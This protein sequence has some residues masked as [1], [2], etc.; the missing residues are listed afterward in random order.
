[1]TST[2]V[3]DNPDLWYHKNPNLLRANVSRRFTTEQAIEIAKCQEDIIYF[4][5]K[6]IKIVSLDHGVVPFDLWPFQEK[7]INT[8]MKERFTICKMPRQVGKSTT[9]VAFLLHYILFNKNVNVAI[10]ANKG[11][12]ARELLSR[13][14]LAYEQLPSFLKPGVVV[15]NKGN[16]E[17]E[18]GS[19]VLAT[20]TSASSVRGSSFNVIFLDELAHVPMNLAEEFFTS[21]YP[22][23]TSGQNTKI[24]IVSTPNGLNMFYRFWVK[25][26][27]ADG[28]PNKNEYTPIEVHWSEVPGRDDA[29]KAQTIANTS[30]EQFRQEFETE[31]LGS[32]DTLISSSRLQLLNEVDQ[33]KPIY[34]QEDLDVHE[35]PQPGRQYVCTV[36]VSEG[37]AQDYSTINVIDVTDVPYKQVAKWRN[38]ETSPY[39]LPGVIY[40]VAS[41]YNQAHVLIEVNSVGQ[42]VADIMHYEMGYENL[43]KIEIK[44]HQ[45]QKVTP[46]FKSHYALGV[47][48]TEP[49]RKTGCANLKYLIEDEKLE[50]YDEDTIEELNNFIMKHGKYQADEGYHDDLVMGLVHFGWLTNQQVFKEIT[51]SDVRKTLQKEKLG[52]IDEMILPPP[53]TDD[54]V[55]PFDKFMDEH[56]DWWFEERGQH[57]PFDDLNFDWRSKL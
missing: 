50:I 52:L 5:K 57:Y 13:L 43:I 7:L 18:N 36:D 42:Q 24:I 20:S 4:C 38:N 21:T 8:F 22:A 10:L 39:V 15:W 9:T 27:L 34:E 26:N 51:D 47:R 1:M 46:G 25:A 31:F 41:K 45:G 2:V 49:V 30:K 33:R 44:A 35:L 28:H 56:G 32:A 6:Y 23:I 37:K 40:G 55:D 17:I 14:Q 48:T 29:W 19:K 12:T 11:T 3:S 54:G 53:L 16:I